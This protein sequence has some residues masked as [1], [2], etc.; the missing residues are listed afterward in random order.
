[1]SVSIDW[2]VESLYRATVRHM[3]EASPGLLTWLRGTKHGFTLDSK[4]PIG[5]MPGPMPESVQKAFAD[6]LAGE[7]MGAGARKGYTYRWIPN[8]LQDA[9]TRV[10]PRSVLVLIGEAARVAL[11][12]PLSAGTR[13]ITPQDLAAAL[14]ET[15]RAR[16]GEIREEYKLVNRLENL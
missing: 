12:I 16:V 15:S 1:R 7:V 14:I 8:H 13:L 4:H 11:K 6:R 2:D 3:A 10:V 9:Q 5:W